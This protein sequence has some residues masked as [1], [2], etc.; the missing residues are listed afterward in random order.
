MVRTL[1]AKMLVRS[2]KCELPMIVTVLL[3]LLIIRIVSIGLNILLASICVAA[4]M[5]VSS[6]VGRVVFECLLL[7]RI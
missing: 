7:I 5:L 2:L 1:W 3:S 4:G 6:A